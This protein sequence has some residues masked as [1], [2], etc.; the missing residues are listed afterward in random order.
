M[1]SRFLLSDRYAPRR[2]QA[3]F[4]QPLLLAVTVP[5]LPPSD[6]PHFLVSNLDGRLLPLVN[7]GRTEVRLGCF[8][9]GSSPE[10]EDDL[11]RQLVE[12]LWEASLKLGMGNAAR[13]AD[14]HQARDQAAAFFKSGGLPLMQASLPR[15]WALRLA[16]EGRLSRR[17]TEADPPDLDQAEAPLTEEEVLDMHGLL[18]WWGTLLAHLDL[19]PSSGDK[20][21][22]WSEPSMVG[23]FTRVGDAAAVLVHNPGWGVALFQGGWGEGP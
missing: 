16:R 21:S 7:R 13:A 23:S 20:A 15:T 8:Q 1:I 5:P 2:G 18:C 6:F 9:T 17:A 14:P 22:F 19:H 3:K 4:D 10:A 12:Q 11:F